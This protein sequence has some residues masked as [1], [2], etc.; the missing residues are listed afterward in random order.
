MIIEG[1][2]LNRDGQ[3]FHQVSTKRPTNYYTPQNLGPGLGLVHISL[4]S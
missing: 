4:L 2:S 1:E 3:Q